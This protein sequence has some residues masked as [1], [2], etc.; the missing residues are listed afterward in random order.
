LVEGGREAE[1]AGGGAGVAA[2]VGRAGCIVGVGGEDGVCVVTACEEAFASAD[3]R[4]RNAM[5]LVCCRKAG[6]F[7]LY[8]FT[9]GLLALQALLKIGPLKTCF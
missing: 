2:G 9:N 7:F 1:S 8:L 6:P 3:L 4:A 5:S